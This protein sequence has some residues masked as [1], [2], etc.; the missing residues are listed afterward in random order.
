M[1]IRDS[2]QSSQKCSTCPKDVVQVANE[3]TTESDFT[4]NVFQIKSNFTPHRN[5]DRGLDHQIDTVNILD[6]K[7]METCSKN[8]LS[9]MKQNLQQ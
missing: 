8:N 6:L 9:K 4:Q 7:G 1:Q 2:K 5:I 3:N